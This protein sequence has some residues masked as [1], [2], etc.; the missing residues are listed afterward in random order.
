MDEFDDK[1][2]IESVSD[3]ESE[4]E[5]P[6]DADDDDDALEMMDDDIDELDSDIELND[7]GD[8]VA[9]LGGDAA[10]PPA[11]LGFEENDDDDYDDADD[12]PDENYLQKLDQDVRHNIVSDFHPELTAHS[13]EEVEAACL[14]IRDDR[15][16]IIDPLHKTV[17]FVT[18][19]ERARVI[20][21][22]AKQINSG[23]K[24]FIE[25]EPNMIDGY[26]I[27]CR[28][29]EEKKI[30][31]IIRRPLPNGSSEYWRLSDL[32]IVG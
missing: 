7:D 27:A 5:K 14:V 16:I 29:F 17:P 24:P 11:L 1:A 21:E 20:G 31:F 6:D 15:G 3:S 30:P 26:L 10:V 22:R 18:R 32:E 2:D 19:Y 4:K 12:E 25:I 9:D 23:A 13:M 8:M 28:E